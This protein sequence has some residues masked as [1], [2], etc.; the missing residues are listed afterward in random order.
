MTVEEIDRRAAPEFPMAG[1]ADMPE[2]IELTPLAWRNVVERAIQLVSEDRVALGADLD[3]GP[4]PP[5]GMRD[6]RGLPMLTQAMIERGWS[7]RRIRK[8][9]GENLP[10]VF[11]KTGPP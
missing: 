8:F 2:E 4:T 1:V 7:E 5:G 6:I 3:C 10:Q 9:L 11:G